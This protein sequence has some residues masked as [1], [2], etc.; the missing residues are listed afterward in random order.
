MQRPLIFN[1]GRGAALQ[2]LIQAVLSKPNATR[3]NVRVDA[4]ARIHSIRNSK[5]AIRNSVLLPL[6]SHDFLDVSNI[7]NIL[8][9]I[10]ETLQSLRTHAPGMVVRRCLS[11]SWD[12]VSLYRTPRPGRPVCTMAMPYRR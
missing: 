8:R 9:Q 12:K 1:V 3:P 5:F 11:L 2:Q 10:T 4:A 7:Q 6:A